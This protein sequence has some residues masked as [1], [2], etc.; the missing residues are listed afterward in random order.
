MCVCVCHRWVL[1]VWD[2]CFLSFFPNF[3]HWSSN[4]SSPYVF[5]WFWWFQ[6]LLK[7][8]KSAMKRLWNTNS[9]D[10]GALGMKPAAS[11]SSLLIF[12]NIS[13]ILWPLSKK[14][15]PPKRCKYLTRDPPPKKV[16]GAYFFQART[17]LVFSS[18]YALFEISVDIE[19]SIVLDLCKCKFFKIH[20]P[21]K[22]GISKIYLHCGPNFWTPRFLR[23]F[24]FEKFAF[25]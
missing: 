13:K 9:T 14:A 22:S 1:K 7:K 21:Q 8:V 2:I 23:S 17:F 4:F 19:N 25:A 10:F 15:V 5:L 3:L 20:R 11:A 12:Y 18:I 24:N 16:N 6:M